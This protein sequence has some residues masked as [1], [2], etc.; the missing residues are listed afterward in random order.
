MFNLNGKRALVTGSTQGIGKAIAKALSE[1][2]ATVIVHGSSSMEK[3][4]KAAKEMSGSPELA[5]ADLS[6]S[7]CAEKL[8]EQ[9]GDVDILVL[10]AS[11]QVRKAWDEITEEEF[12]F[13]INTNLKASLA[14]IQKYAPHMK[15]Q[16]WGRIVTVGSVQQYKPHKDMAVY[17]AS[18]CGQMSLVTNLGKQLA[19]FG[20]TI[21]NLSPGVIAT[22]R[23]DAALSDEEYRTKVI[24]GI[25]A[26][27]A[28]TAEDCAGAAVL[29][30]SEAGRYIVGTDVIVDGG[31]HL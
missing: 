4:Q 23:N 26:G 29:L 25:P 19:P 11:V 1:Q 24:A 28:G 16:N 13:Q 3:C 20:I 12:D 7:D 5:V 10:N 18:K 27:C 31:M 17:A 15:E 9:T 30:C 2:G 8:Y 21:N 6:K 14:L 22:P